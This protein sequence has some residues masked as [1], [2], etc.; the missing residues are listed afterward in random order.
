MASTANN[1]ANADGKVLFTTLPNE[2]VGEVASR[3]E[4]AGLL[5]LRLIL[6]K[7]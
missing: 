3:L 7:S 4:P 6:P 5:K 2:L 1:P